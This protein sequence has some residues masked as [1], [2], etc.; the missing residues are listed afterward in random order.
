MRKGSC[1]PEPI[2]TLKEDKA[3]LVIAPLSVALA[4]RFTDST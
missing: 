4:N 2:C 3:L 1:K